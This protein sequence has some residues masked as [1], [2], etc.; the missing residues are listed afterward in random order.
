MSE[1]QRMNILAGTASSTN[2]LNESKSENLNLEAIEIIDKFEYLQK[3]FKYILLNSKSNHNPYHDLNHLLTVMKYC[4]YG[5]IAEKI[6]DEKELRELLITAIFHDVNHSGGKKTD[7]IN[8]KNSK[9]IIKE[10]VTSENIDVDSDSMN[11]ILDATQYPYVL[12]GKDL[13]LRQAI[14]RDADLM[15]VYEYNWIHQNINGLSS[16]LK[17]DFIDFLKPQRKF[18]ENA[19]FNTSWGKKLKKEKWNGVMKQFK[20]LEDACSVKLKS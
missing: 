10:F 11:E 16:E 1:K 14:I 4:Y 13:N 3:A 18:L 5:A 17:M 12:E 15:Q 19:E 20:M 9:K 2:S 6:K 7:D 8:I